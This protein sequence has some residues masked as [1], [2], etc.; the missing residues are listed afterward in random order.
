MEDTMMTCSICDQ[1][2]NSE[3]E[4]REHQQTVHAAAVNSRRRSHDEDE[5][6]SDDQEYAA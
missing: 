5:L 1:F 6:D 2:F 3:Q 4:L